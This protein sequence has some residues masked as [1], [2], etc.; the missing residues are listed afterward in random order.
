M[1]LKS[2]YITLVALIILTATPRAFDQLADLKNLAQERFRVEL[3]NIFW[4][5][6]TPDARR[7]DARRYSE[8]LARAEAASAPACDDSIVIKAARANKNMSGLARSTTPAANLEHRRF[9]AVD[10]PSPDNLIADAGAPPD[11]NVEAFE[12]AESSQA[13]T[14]GEVVLIARNFQ[15]YPLFDET[16]GPARVEDAVARFKLSTDDEPP[17]P[18]KRDLG[19]AKR[20][21]HKFVQTS[22]QIRLPENLDKML[23]ETM[24]NSDAL[25]KAQQALAPAK[26]KCRIRVLQ[27][28]VAPEAP[29]PLEKPPTIS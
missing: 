2:R 15:D 7:D 16:A 6:T 13:A 14:Q 25:I 24:L 19:E 10:E 27:P 3:L 9:I 22:F 5:F 20:F 1:R 21:A 28:R 17:A 12:A 4:N 8:L 18:P 23:N 26:A 11:P 29:R